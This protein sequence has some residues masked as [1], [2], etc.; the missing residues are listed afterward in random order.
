MAQGPDARRRSHPRTPLFSTRTAALRISLN[1]AEHLCPLTFS[2]VPRAGLLSRSIRATTDSQPAFR[3]AFLL[4]TSY[5]KHIDNKF[6]LGLATV[7]MMSVASCSSSS[8]P[9]TVK[10]TPSLPPCPTRA[11]A[12]VDYLTGKEV[13]SGSA[14]SPLPAP[15][16][17]P[18]A[19]PGGVTREKAI[20]VAKRNTVG[21]VVSATLGRE[22][23]LTTY[24][25]T[26][27]DPWV[28]VVIFA[29]RYGFMHT[30]CAAR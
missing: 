9:V 30:E 16:V 10:P 15:G 27:N 8:T 11:A 2:S 28:W 20:E 1:L 22:S 18:L 26:P 13:M 25:H 21:R 7:A 19:P 4:Q 24:G 14:P 3:V 5:T 17:D 29:G 12:Y 23:A 6:A